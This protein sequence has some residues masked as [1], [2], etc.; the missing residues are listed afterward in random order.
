MRNILLLSIGGAVIV[1]GVA[2]YM[3]FGT[4]PE[5]VTTT[6]GGEVTT[7]EQ[8]NEEVKIPMSGNGSLSA[9]LA[10][11]QNLECS[12]EYTPQ[13]E[14]GAA[15]QGTY[16][17]SRG[18]MRGDFVVDSMGTQMV[19]SMIID[20]ESMYSWSEIDGQ[21]YGMKMTLSELETSQTDDTAPEANEA[22]PLDESVKYNCKPWVNID[23]SIF[24]PP[25]DIIFTDYSAVV[26][27]GMEF[28]TSYEG[29]AG[30]DACAACDQ[31]T[32]EAR[33]QCRAMMSCE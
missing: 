31:A 25:T 28:G 6:D 2:L 22:V 15:T 18:R 10:F 16:F 32:G 12:I 33:T 1:G 26:D 9:L 17:T 20:D 24:E 27:M 11:G 23:G 4:A 19:S 5:E 14:G 29:G 30:A 21:K 7:E 3:I 8:T 13:V